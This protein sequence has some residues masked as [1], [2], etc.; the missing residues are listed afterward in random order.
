MPLPEANSWI[1]RIIDEPPR[2][3]GGGDVIIGKIGKADMAAIGKNITQV[4]NT[5]GEPKPGDSEEITKAIKGLR[6]ELQKLAPQLSERHRVLA[7]NK[8]DTIAAEL[9]KAEGD[10]SGDLIRSAGDWLVDNIP[11]IGGAL[12]S[13][14]IPDPVGRVL[15]S[16]GTATIAWVK[17]L[18]SRFTS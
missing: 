14:F 18:R 7:E 9:Q 15:L 3:H 5:L 16:A 10:P 13:A 6:E 2:A 4:K 12:L 8:I 1:D 11:A 17:A